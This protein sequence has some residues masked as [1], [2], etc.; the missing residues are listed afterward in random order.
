MNYRPEGCLYKTPVNQRLI[1]SAEGLT[2]AMNCG[3]IIEARVSV[4]TSSHDLIIDLPCAKGV[5]LTRGRR[6][7][8]SGKAKPVI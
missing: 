2:E 8:Y 3:T 5:I 7:R 4:C 6:T 1:S